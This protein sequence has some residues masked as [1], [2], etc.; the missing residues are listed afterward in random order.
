MI[1]DPGPGEPIRTPG[2]PVELDVPELFVF[3]FDGT[4]VDQRG[5]WLLLQELFGTRGAGKELTEQY[6]AEVID[7]QEWCERNVDL[8]AERGVRRRHIQRA[9][10]AV[11]LTRGANELLELLQDG[12]VPYGVVSGGVRGLQAV[13]D[14]FEPDFRYA[15]EIQFADGKAAGANS[16]DGNDSE[17]E[18]LVGARA[19][20]GP[21]DKDAVL[22]DLCAEYD[23]DLSEVF[24]VGDS[25]TDVEAFAVAGW[26][27]AFDPDERI[28]DS[29]IEQTD[30]VVEDRDMAHLTNLL[31][32]L[33][34]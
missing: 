17:G 7:F 2:G 30:L 23:V 26:S 34:L 18:E 13:L 24:Y 29:V 11:K 16:G 3:D 14:P 22:D 1:V 4:L 19:R 21:D 15:N 5:G 20:V 6:D 8:L 9:A 25:H 12:D 33:G 32:D 27:V 28:G 31:T 10:A